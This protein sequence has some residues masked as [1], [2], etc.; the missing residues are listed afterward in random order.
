MKIFLTTTFG[1]FL[2]CST[3]FAQMQWPQVYEIKDD[4]AYW[5]H[6][7]PEHWVMLEDKAGK[8]TFDEVLALADKGMFHS[9]KTS[10]DSLANT[11]WIA[12]K[13]QNTMNREA[14]VSLNS[15]SNTDEFYVQKDS[16]QWEHF[17]SGKLND[18]NKKN[19][20]KR[21]D[22][23]PVILQPG[24]IYSVYQLVKNKKPGLGK[25][26]QVAVV[27][28][29]KIL[30][31]YYID[32]VDKRE[33]I[34]S[35]QQIQEAFMI[36]LLLIS[37]LISLFYYRVT[38]EK[39]YLYFALFAIFLAINRCYNISAS[40]T[41]WF[42]PDWAR[43]VGYI[44]YAWAFIPFFLIQFIRTFFGL[45]QKYPK[46]D[47]VVFIAGLLNLLFGI[48]CLIL[49]MF[50]VNSESAKI[51]DQIFRFF[52]FRLV[53]SGIIITSFLYIRNKKFRIVIIGTIPLMFLYLVTSFFEFG[54]SGGLLNIPSFLKPLF[55]NFR[56]AEMI[57]L[58]WLILCF[59]RVLIMR[60]DALQKE[61]AQQLIDKE[62][63][64]NELVAGQ[65]IQ[66]EKDVAER[67]AD[68]K[69]SLEELKATQAQL[70]QS[71][72]MAS[73]GELTA[74]IAHEIQN[75][76]NFVNNFS[77]VSNEL[78]D[79]MEDELVKGNYAGAR[80]VA[81][82]IR[83]NLEKINHHGKR[84]DAIVKGMLQHSRV[85]N[86]A[87]EPTNINALADEY[88]RLA[89]HGLRA[90]D[91]SF[92]VS[93]E[94]DFDENV[95]KIGIIPQDIG[96]VILNLITNA[97]YAVT[98]KKQQSLPGYEPTVTVSTHKSG[99]KVEIKV[100]DN[101]NGITAKV[102]DKIYQPFFTTKPSGQGTG[103]G[104]SMSY[105]I[106][107]KSHG[108]ELRVETKEGE[109]AVFTIVLPV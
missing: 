87:K 70:I 32:Y 106:V 19:G 93:L 29:D 45:K 73:L 69:Q 84:A 37:I 55:D 13:L 47:K 48:T 61:N 65:K 4:T 101:G 17:T 46:W 75:P 23:I 8:W 103:L 64:R 58:T 78:I 92:N 40:Y 68:L 53:P 82:D 91:K 98:E 33:F 30:Q 34:F 108:G 72:K 1:L 96:R 107:T 24:E 51:T 88:L 62:K 54:D 79:E 99:D 38:R 44:G 39:A 95:G 15:M 66:L 49:F 94:T 2:L 109:G 63:E 9:V 20:L 11:Y 86:G 21:A 3:I 35:T 6:I 18:W 104:L 14:R 97:F 105:E 77:E 36:G 10:Y 41:Y 28:T 56:L 43:Y 25:D 71:E 26:F 52:S 16:M 27:S 74:G 81:S 83:Q 22:C 102:L 12:Y 31:D 50:K 57:C 80:A 76:L 60:F 5:Q 42:Q 90:K 100:A 59:V 7:T 89:Y 67:T 85:S